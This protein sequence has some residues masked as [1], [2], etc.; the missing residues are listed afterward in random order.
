[1]RGARLCD[2]LNSASHIACGRGEIAAAEHWLVEARALEDPARPPR[3][4]AVRCNSE[5]AWRM[6]V[7]DHAGAL[8]LPLVIAIIHT[9]H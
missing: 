2:T 4:R 9:G 5:A 1:M 7:G 3:A 6:Y 8:P